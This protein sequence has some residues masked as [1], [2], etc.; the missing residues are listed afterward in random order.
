MMSSNPITHDQA[1]KLAA[2]I[3]SLRP[4]WDTPGVLHAIGRARERGDGTAVAVAAIRAAASPSNR[5]PAVIALD[6]EHWREPAHVMATPTPPGRCVRCGTFHTA[7][8]CARP[9]GDVAAGVST[10][11]AALAKAKADVAAAREARL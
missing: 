9:A 5:T 10:V 2:F 6:G 4:D 1:T 11:R 3:S 8:E 7:P